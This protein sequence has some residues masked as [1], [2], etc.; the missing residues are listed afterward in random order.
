MILLTELTLVNSDF[1]YGKIKY[2]S[3]NHCKDVDFENYLTLIL[4]SGDQEISE[5]AIGR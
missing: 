2:K 3:E 1:L 4:S 5:P